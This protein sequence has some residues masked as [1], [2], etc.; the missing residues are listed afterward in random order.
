[1]AK[2]KKESLGD[3]NEKELISLAKA[4]IKAK[5]E[6][7]KLPEL[8]KYLTP[9]RVF[10]TLYKNGKLRGCIGSF[11]EEPLEK[12]ICNC[13][14]AAAFSDFRFPP[15]SKEELNK[16]KVEI[17]ILDEPVELKYKDSADL[18]KKLATAKPGVIIRYGDYSATF[19]PQVWEQL[20]EPEEFLS[21]LCLK[22]GIEPTAWKNANLDIFTYGVKIISELEK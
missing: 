7:S 15:L 20:P 22:A 14:V 3:L 2:K 12:A 17:S 21:N 10:V 13:A 1:M 6:N 4:A 18:L 8:N 5:L 16:I 9:A 19:L 11:V